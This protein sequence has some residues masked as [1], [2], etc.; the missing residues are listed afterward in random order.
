M[1]FRGFTIP[2]MVRLFGRGS[3]LSFEL[4][5]VEAGMEADGD[6]SIDSAKLHV[7]NVARTYEAAAQ[8]QQLG[9]EQ[10]RIQL[11]QPHRLKGLFPVPHSTVMAPD[12]HDSFSRPIFYPIPRTRF[13]E[14]PK[15]RLLCARR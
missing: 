14:E 4:L 12:F 9:I 2:L 3:H 6:H 15:H 11:I 10:F 5:Q 7:K 13:H 1:E 8:D